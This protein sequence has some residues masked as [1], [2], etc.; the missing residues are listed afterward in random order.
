M[1]FAAK[2][3]AVR[4]DPEHPPHIRNTNQLEVV[5]S[6]VL[7]NIQIVTPSLEDPLQI[8]S[9]PQPTSSPSPPFSPRSPPICFLSSS[10]PLPSPSPLSPPPLLLYSSSSSSSPL[11]STPSLTSPSPRPLSLSLSPKSERNRRL[12]LETSSP[13]TAPPM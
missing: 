1:H 10:L 8:C 4:I 11:F 5:K 3:N 12:A 6:L 9:H 7:A 2:R 13:Q